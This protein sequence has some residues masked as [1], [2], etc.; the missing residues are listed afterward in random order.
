MITIIQVL[1]IIFA[2][3]AWS[4]AALRLKDKSI[5]ISGFIFWSL[6]WLFVIIFAALPN[7]FNWLS[8]LFGIG[9]PTD[10]AIYISIILL[11]YLIFR[12]YVRMDRQSQEIT[13]LVREIATSKK[14]SSRKKK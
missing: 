3:F 4:R 2:A 8:T 13:K 10:L 12:L 9:R 6:I 11:F 1:M 5:S 7:A 14:A